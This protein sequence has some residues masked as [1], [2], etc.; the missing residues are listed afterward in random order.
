MAYNFIIGNL[1]LPLMR[2]FKR[3]TDIHTLNKVSNERVR[4]DFIY[5]C[6]EKWSTLDKCQK[7]AKSERVF[8]NKVKKYFIKLY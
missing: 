1:P 8:R 6:C 7:S 2:M 3:N 5:K 4:R